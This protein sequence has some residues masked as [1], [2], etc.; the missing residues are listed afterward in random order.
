VLRA[1]RQAYYAPANLGHAGLGSECYCHFTSPI[2]RYPD[3]VC[4]R[5]LLASLG[6]AERAPRAGSMQELGE[7]C[8]QR[9]RDAMKVE[10]DADDVARCFALERALYAGNAERTFSG[11][12]VGLISA[13]AFLAFGEEPAGS[14]EATTFD[15]EGMLPARVL[16]AATAA[17]AGG[18]DWW[19]LNEEGT[20]LSGERSGMALRLGDPMAVSVDRVDAPRGRVDLVPAEAKETN[21][22][23]GVRLERKTAA[24]GA[25]RKGPASGTKRKGPLDASS[26]KARKASSS[27]SARKR[28]QRRRAG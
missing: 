2:R 18:R 6:H 19:Q 10:R 24:S 5:A 20:I 15:Y 23:S 22:A 26:G 17:L 25:A 3:L 28:S 7:W 14:G 13:G 11:E 8:S 9:E 16:A 4:H 1:L 21:P 27:G 12:I